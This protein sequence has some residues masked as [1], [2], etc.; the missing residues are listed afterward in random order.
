MHLQR[1]FSYSIPC[2]EHNDSDGHLLLHILK[3]PP[4]ELT[5]DTRALTTIPMEGRQMEA[6]FIILL[7]ICAGYKALPSGQPI[8]NIDPQCLIQIWELSN[9]TM[10]SQYAILSL[11]SDMS[12]ARWVYPEHVAALS[13]CVTNALLLPPDN[14]STS[15]ICP[16]VWRITRITDQ[17]CLGRRR[18]EEERHDA[19]IEANRAIAKLNTFRATMEVYGRSNTRLLT[20]TR[21]SVSGSL[22]PAG[23][24]LPVYAD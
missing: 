23:R 4:S 19:T 20:C 22:V 15:I 9:V 7:H 2:S 14:R 11:L 17:M 10:S 8:G 24:W 12:T 21:P 18:T 6:L 16:V 3:I 13:I 5:L 1:T